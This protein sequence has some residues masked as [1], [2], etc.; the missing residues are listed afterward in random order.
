MIKIIYDKEVDAATIYLKDVCRG[1]SVLT[2]PC[3]PLKVN[4][5]INLDFDKDG[6]MIS[7]EVLGA[8]K[9]L[10]KEVLDEVVVP[11]K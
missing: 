9:K 10:P 6:R 11:I 8:S 1:E 2:Y 3:N 5:E 7:I 4:G